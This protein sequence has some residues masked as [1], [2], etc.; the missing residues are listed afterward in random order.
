VTLDDDEDF[1]DEGATTARHVKPPT[2]FD[3]T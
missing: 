3:H 1:D 2:A